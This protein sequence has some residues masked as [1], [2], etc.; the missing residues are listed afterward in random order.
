MNKRLACDAR[1]LHT[2]VTFFSLKQGSQDPITTHFKHARRSPIIAER[3]LIMRTYL[4]ILFPMASLTIRILHTINNSTRLCLSHNTTHRH[5]QRHRH[6]H[7]TWWGAGATEGRG[8]CT[9]TALICSLKAFTE[10]SL[11]F[12]CMVTKVALSLQSYYSTS[13]SNNNKVYL[14]IDSAVEATKALYRL[15]IIAFTF[16]S[17]STSQIFR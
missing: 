16:F 17:G 4:T 12:H 9:G 14:D 2:C 7:W 5:R 11:K 1:P 15:L 8:G 6:R 3:Y 13:S 10:V